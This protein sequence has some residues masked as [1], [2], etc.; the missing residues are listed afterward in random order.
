[1]Y[2]PNDQIGPYTLIRRLGQGAS[3]IVWLAERR[4]SVLTTQVALKIPM[5]EDADLDSISKE[6]H[7]WQAASGHPNVLPVIEADTYEGQVVIISEYANGG[8]LKDWL[9]RNGGKAP[10]IESAMIMVS[11]I[12]AGLEHLHTQG[13]VHCDLKLS[14]VLLQ[15]ELPRITDFGVSR[16]L[17]STVLTKHLSGTPA[18]MPPEAI[19]GKLSKQ[20]DLWAAGVILYVL[21][22]GQLPFP[23][24]SMGPLILAIQQHEPEPLPSSVPA[25]VQRVISRALLKD[26]TMRFSSALEMRTILNNP[27]SNVG[28]VQP[29]HKPV[30]SL[31]LTDV[32]REDKSQSS[33]LRV[34]V[35]SID[36][37]E[38][39]WI[40]SGEFTMGS[41]T[42]ESHEAPAHTVYLEGFWIYKH[43]VTVGQFRKFCADTGRTMRH[44]PGWGWKDENPMVNVSWEY[45]NAFSMWAGVQLPTEAEWEKAARGTDERIFPWG[46]DWFSD[47]CKNSVGGRRQNGV[48]PVGSYPEG[49]SKYGVH[50]MAGNVWEWCADWYDSGYYTISTVSNPQGP[51]FGV[52]RVLRGGSWGNERMQDFR[53]TC[54]VM[55]DPVARGGSIGFRCVS[56]TAPPTG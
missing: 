34:R 15:G 1:M 38:M 8:T 4:S 18:Y 42:G 30:L 52:R 37:A 22:C 7:L 25:H 26:P 53:A 24:K 27:N 20:S 9:D 29:L 50:D 2:R 31:P 40:P 3:G 55:C 35:N 44:T 33:I 6:A 51:F 23:Q 28:L 17:R 56:R 11:G 14:N 13:V 39:I 48:A 43:A 54:R 21:I 36:G 16:V 5:D 41:T 10:S 47:R 12:L 49:V 19:D 46:N 32:F 45:A